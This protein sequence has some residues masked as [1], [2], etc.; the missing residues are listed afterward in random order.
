[1][2]IVDKKKYSKYLLLGLLLVVVVILYLPV[3]DFEFLSLQDKNMLTENKILQQD[4]FSVIKMAFSKEGTSNLSLWSGLS[5]SVDYAI[6]K[7][8]PR[9]Y[10]L[11]NLILYL[12]C[13][14]ALFFFILKMFK[15][16]L[17][18]LLVTIPFALLATHVEV[19]VWISQRETMIYFLLFFLCLISY[20]IY[21]EKNKAV[22][23]LVL[24]VI[25]FLMTSLSKGS[26][27]PLLITI[28]LIDF[29][30]ARALGKQVIIEKIPFI[31][32]F[33]L[34]YLFIP[35][36]KA[37]SIYQN[38][39]HD[40]IYEIM[41]SQ[42]SYGSKNMFFIICFSLSYYIVSFFNPQVISFIHPFP[43]F[44]DGLLPI[45]YYVSFLGILILISLII[46]LI[47]KDRSGNKREW[48]FG[49]IFFVVNIGMYLHIFPYN[50]ISM[51]ADRHSFVAHTGLLIIVAS[52]IIHLVNKKGKRYRYFFLPLAFVFLAAI[53]I[54]HTVKKR[55]YL[56][57]WQ[58]DKT[59]YSYL[60]S[61]NKNTFFA[62]NNRGIYYYKN[63]KY[64]EAVKDFSRALKKDTDFLHRLYKAHVYNNRGAAHKN[65]GLFHNAINDLQTSLK[66]SPDNEK[67]LYNLES[68]YLKLNSIDEN[69][70]HFNNLLE[71]NPENA[72]LLIEIGFLKNKIGLYQYALEDFEKVW[73]L[74]PENYKAFYYSGLSY[75][76]LYQY[77]N[78][79]INFE[80]AISIN[81]QL[82][83]VFLNKAIT[84]NN[85]KSY[86]R[87]IKN[88]DR[89]IELDPEN[90]QAYLLRGNSY[91]EL[92]NFQWACND[93]KKAKELGHEDA[94]IVIERHCY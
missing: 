21:L 41:Y 26:I 45:V 7:E 18:A 73:Q 87:A 67:A 59:L 68:L 4:M 50:N 83:E 5:F 54:H 12:L 28:I 23:W 13:I 31:A 94:S 39:M 27:G 14:V 91:Y 88:Y 38:I 30:Y 61:N 17:F 85:K 74:E 36:F 9:V 42:R 48:L 75:L 8:N 11:H 47:V 92:Q 65:L 71:K 40:E 58:N 25:F 51:V 32:V 60:I 53:L 33:I 10:H 6:G 29:Y 81:S 77:D 22:P 19:V 52:I 76:Y 3:K 63:G 93:W 35:E 66:I 49:F 57:A 72:E 62:Y 84:L 82:P 69:L 89:A 55:N 2:Q 90:A 56:P 64:N 79:L 43:Q 78:A 24:S 16:T 46:I 1:M 34:T 20:V 44:Q 86:T 70:S 37:D 15:K 80:K